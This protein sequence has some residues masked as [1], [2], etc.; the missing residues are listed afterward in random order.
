VEKRKKK[1]ADGVDGNYVEPMGIFEIDDAVAD[2]IG[3]LHQVNERMAEKYIFRSI[4]TGNAQ[5]LRNGPVNGYLCVEK[6]GFFSDQL[7]FVET[8]QRVGRIFH[9]RGQRGIGEPK[10]TRRRFVEIMRQ[11]SESIGIPFEIQEIALPVETE[12]ALETLLG[13][14]PQLLPEKDPDR[15]LSRMPKRWIAYIVRQTC[16]PDDGR[17]LIPVKFQELPAGIRIF[18]TQ[19]ISYR[20]A[21]RPAYGCHFQAMGKPVMDKDRPGQRKDLG[22]VLQTAEG[23]RKNDPVVVA[24]KRGPRLAALA[25]LSP[26]SS[27]GAHRRIQLLPVHAVFA[28][29]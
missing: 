6:P 10:P 8:V 5:F 20:P 21:E 1:I 9:D 14:S 22:L 3:S 29:A 4:G 27:A 7:A 28:I 2:I 19:R 16:G 18:F 25:T 17:Q 12:L 23:G 13:F 24:Q 11:R 26:R 15:L